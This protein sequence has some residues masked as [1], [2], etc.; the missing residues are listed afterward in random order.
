MRQVKVQLRVGI[1]AALLFSVCVSGRTAGQLDESFQVGSGFNNVVYTLAVQADGR[2]LTG[3]IFDSYGNV[4]SK[5]LAR[6]LPDGTLDGTFNVGSGPDAAIKTI[7]PLADNGIVVGGDFQNINGIPRARLAWLKSDGAVDTNRVADVG[8]PF[9]AARLLPDGKLLVTGSFSTVA[10]ESRR[11]IARLNADATVD[12]GF[13]PG[14]N[15][16]FAASAPLLLP[17]GRLLLNASWTAGPTPRSLLFRMNSDGTLDPSFDQDGVLGFVSALG[18]LPDGS[19]VA[20]HTGPILTKL[21]ATGVLDLSFTN[22]APLTSATLLQPLGDGRFLWGGSTLGPEGQRAHLYRLFADGSIDDS[23]SAN[24]D[25]TACCA[26]EQ[27]DGN[28]LVGGTFTTVNGIAR[29]RIARLRGDDRTGVPVVAWNGSH[30]GVEERAGVVEVPLF[31][32]GNLDGGV[33]VQYST[34]GTT[35]SPGQDFVPA[36]GNVTFAPGD[37]VKLVRVEVLED[38]LP[39]EDETFE[40]ILSGDSALTNRAVATVWIFSDEGFIEPASTTQTVS[41]IAHRFE[42]SAQ[43]HGGRPYRATVDVNQVGGTADA[44]DLGPV[45]GRIFFLRGQAKAVQPMILNDDAVFE[46]DETFIV[47]FANPSAGFALGFFE[48]QTV[49]ITDND[50]ASRPGEG[51]NQPA[52]LF[53]LPDGGLLLSGS[54]ATIHGARKSWLAKLGPEGTLDASFNPGVN[55]TPRVLGVLTNGGIML[56]VNQGFFLNQS[57]NR[58]WRLNAD[59]TRDT[60]FSSDYF[61][62]GPSPTPTT[63]PG[64]STFPIV[65]TPGGGLA[66][67]LL[68]AN[69]SL[70]I[71]EL[72]QLNSLG[73]PVNGFAAKAFSAASSS[74]AVQLAPQSGGRWLV[75]GRVF[76]PQRPFETYSTAL[77]RDLLRLDAQGAADLSFMPRLGPSF[78]TDL[79]TRILVLSD[80][81]ILVI[82]RFTSVDGVAR[83][84]LARL[85]PDGALDPT[86]TPDLSSVA[87]YVPSPTAL[88]LQTDDKLLLSLPTTIG[89]WRLVRLN[90]DGSIDP[91][92]ASDAIADQAITSIAVLADGRLA[93]SGSFLHFGN[94]FRARLAW[95]DA[96]G[97]LLPDVSVELGAPGLELD[98]TKLTIRSRLPGR[99][100]VERSTELQAWE[101][102]ASQ[103]I[104][105]GEQQVLLPLSTGKEGFYRARLDP[106]YRGLSK[107]SAFRAF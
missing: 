11:W 6:L 52:N 22:G 93:V 10:G 104:T 20:A 24:L 42:I 75:A 59:G 38:L 107:R 48:R 1:V 9:S 54:F 30:F 13:N 50:L 45:P 96:G 4:A 26:A 43:R 53:A 103:T 92:F 5:C 46:G 74:T 41:E 31:R 47:E 106:Q 57:T 62:P 23:F 16:F 27:P 95:L 68:G 49:V 88:A 101:P 98:R 36:T 80:D 3:G 15:M 64:F 56:E 65:P 34:R 87:S 78:L 91:G 40:V 67:G 61:R 105:A 2:I 19:Y 94:Q 39:E 66:F 84:G 51:L 100:V 60:T 71:T 21:F 58:Y 25:F 28:I 32:T 55:G 29:N 8:F 14:T 17:D 97:R 81:R 33:T 86:F 83:N 90:P 89:N 7:L 77:R 99:V 63:S 85:L 69:S 35:A 102:L 44:N 76:I 37:R 73:Q 82:G 79:V 72:F 70:Q 18:L 12:A